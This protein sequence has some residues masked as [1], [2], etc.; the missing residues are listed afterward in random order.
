MTAPLS[1]GFNVPFTE[2]LEEALKRKVVLPDVYYGKLQGIARQQAF[3][4]AG[5]AS[6]DQLSIVKKSLDE[7]M[8]SGLSFDQWKRGVLTAGAL[9]LPAHRLDNIFRTNL[10]GS[11]MAGRWEQILRNS[12]TRPFL[13]YDA[14]NDSRVRPSHLAFDNII[15]RFDDP[16]WKKNSPPNGY[17]CRCSIISLTESQ[18]K[19]RSGKGKGLKNKA[20]LED[21]TKA[22]PDEGWNYNPSDRL[23]GLKKAAKEKAAA[24]PK[25][26]EPLPELSG[27]PINSW[28][29]V[30]EQKGSNPGGTYEADDGV[31][32]YVKFPEDKSRAYNEVLAGKLYE[33]AGIDVPE[34]MIVRQNGKIGLASRIIDGLEKNAEALKAGNITG[35]H[36]GFGMDAWLANWDVIGLGFDNMLIK[37]GR[38]IRVDTG[39]A[40][41]FRAQGA[42][43]GAAF[44]KAVTEIKSL[45]SAAQN[46]QAAQVFGSLTDGQVKASVARVISLDDDLIRSVVNE[47][48]PGDLAQKN[49]LADLLLARKKD[50]IGQFPDVLPKIDGAIKAAIKA[51]KMKVELHLTELDE[52]IVAAA[53]GIN[54]RASSNGVFIAKDIERVNDAAGKYQALLRASNALSAQ[55]LER[56]EQHY[57]TWIL[58]LNKAIV[59]GVGTNA[60]SIEG[61]FDGLD[62]GLFTINE[63]LV[64]PKFSPWMFGDGPLFVKVDVLDILRGVEQATGKS[65]YL[66]E[67]SVPHHYDKAK[68]FDKM[69]EEYKRALWSWTPGHIYRDVSKE[70]VK[71]ANFGIQPA[72]EVLQYERLINDAIKAAPKEVQHVGKSTRGIMDRQRDAKEYYDKMR[73]IQDNNGV[74]QFETIS[75]ST[76]GD[77]PGFD[78]LVHIHIDGKTGVHIDPISQ[79]GGNGGSENEVLF[80]TEQKFRVHELAEID[81][82]YHVY[83]KEI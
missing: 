3:S 65:A 39:G 69:P 73:A 70:L 63:A 5:L 80:G 72:D 67:A 9:D 54:Y 43:K 49:A 13:M 22:K 75:S 30:G 74:Y 10:Q 81:S 71:R 20:M 29:K 76:V 82:V 4:V 23:A 50:L 36:E 32:W 33:K 37:G 24:V 57:S 17:R 6:L 66:T 60:K 58:K 83:L 1:I 34:M 48:G 40:L 11:Y 77:K 45:R 19:A 16:F 12:E 64:K 53:K 21:G 7:A 62:R 35:V 2:A 51:E 27:T 14:I 47:F 44:G 41:L 26:A 31:Q 61:F 38:A 25:I 79:F 78:K 59:D 52:A 8:K 42:E 46:S 68:Y 18:A 55:S 28:K 56:A 15:R